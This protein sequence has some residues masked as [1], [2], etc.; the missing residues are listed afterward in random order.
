MQKKQFS[1]RDLALAALLAAL[2]ATLTMVLYAPSYGPIQLRFS[3]ALTVLPFLFPAATPGLFMGCL[4]ANLLSPYGP[5]DV[6]FGS[7]ATLLAA[8]LTQKC[9]NKWLA[10]L[11]PVLCNGVIIGATIA[12]AQ[13]GMTEAFM[14]AFLYNMVTVGAGQLVACYGLGMIV[15][16]VLPRVAFFRDMISAE[17]LGKLEQ[18]PPVSL[19]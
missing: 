2:Y 11:P 7:L 17:K 3:E 6:V 9:N 4:I 1:T 15:L 10:P 16:N 18:I 5:I 14:A 12:Y 8:Y 13:V 19:Q